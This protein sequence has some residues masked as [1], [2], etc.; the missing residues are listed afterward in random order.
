MNQSLRYADGLPMNTSTNPT[1]NAFKYT[2]K[3]F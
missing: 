1:A 2:A 3:I